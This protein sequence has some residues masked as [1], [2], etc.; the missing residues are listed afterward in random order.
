LTVDW[1]VSGGCCIGSS[2]GGYKMEF[3]F[4]FFGFISSLIGIGAF[5]YGF[6]K[7]FFNQQSTPSLFIIC[8]VSASIIEGLFWNILCKLKGWPYHMGGSGNEPHGFHA[9]IWGIITICPVIFLALLA[10]RKPY[11]VNWISFLKWI[12]STDFLL[13]ILYGVFAGFS[14]VAFY[15]LG[16]RNFIES[17]H[18][19]YAK[20][21]MTI[22]L[23]WSSI[24]SLSA[25]LSFLLLCFFPKIF[26]NNIGDI[27]LP[28]LQIPFSVILSLLAVLFFLCVAPYVPGSDQ[29]RGLFTGFALR[30]GLFCGIIVAITKLGYKSIL[31]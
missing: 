13:I 16:I 26:F 15:D 23:L 6:F 18:L 3:T 22:V 11:L 1:E 12:L 27:F 25:Y 20:Q 29:L 7:W 4:R 17:M 2:K 30:F 19:G 5:V 10:N 8:A 31:Q 21:E 28:L 14:A 9:F 24:I